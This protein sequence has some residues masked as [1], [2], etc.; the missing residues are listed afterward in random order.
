MRRKRLNSNLPS[1][2]PVVRAEAVGIGEEFVD[3][4]WWANPDPFS[5]M[6]EVEGHGEAHAKT[7]VEESRHVWLEDI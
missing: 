2:A 5:V 7:F 3:I 4:A 6:E 1:A